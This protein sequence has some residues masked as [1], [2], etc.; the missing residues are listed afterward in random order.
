MNE[1]IYLCVSR[2]IVTIFNLL[3]SRSFIVR[4]AAR[5]SVQEIAQA[6]GASYL[7]MFIRDLRQKLTRGYQVHVMIYTV[8]CLVASLQSFLQP[9]D[10]DPCFNDIFAVSREKS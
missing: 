8:H 10:L 1:V 3:L 6:L 2:V 4:Q 7:P 9:G 5:K